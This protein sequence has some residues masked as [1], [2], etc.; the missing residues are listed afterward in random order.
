MVQEL[1]QVLSPIEKEDQ[2]DVS[3]ERDPVLVAL[4]PYGSEDD[5]SGSQQSIKPKVGSRTY[6]YS[7]IIF[8]NS[9]DLFFSCYEFKDGKSGSN[10]EEATLTSQQ[11][12]PKGRGKRKRQSTEKA[13]EGEGS[14]KQQQREG[15]R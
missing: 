8:K 7:N 5:Y 14:K 15:R 9:V 2:E 4:F 3:K 11:E 10:P 6:F 12:T 1:K 13:I